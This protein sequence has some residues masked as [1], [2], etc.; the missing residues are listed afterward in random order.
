VEKQEKAP[1]SLCFIVSSVQIMG[2]QKN[3]KLIQ[4]KSDKNELKSQLSHFWIRF[5]FSA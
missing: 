3:P 2:H 5:L 4:Q 1:E